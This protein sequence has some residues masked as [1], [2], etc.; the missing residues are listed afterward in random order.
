MLRKHR[1]V[2]WLAAAVLCSSM[3]SSLAAMDELAERYVKLVLA[4]GVHDA[5]YVDAFY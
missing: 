1:R 4:V 3:Q 2:T 5:D